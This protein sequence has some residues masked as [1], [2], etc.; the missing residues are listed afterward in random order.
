MTVSN[1]LLYLISHVLANTVT[2]SRLDICPEGWDGKRG[3]TEKGNSF[4]SVSSSCTLGKWRKKDSQL[5]VWVENAWKYPFPMIFI[6]LPLLRHKKNT[7]LSCKGKSQCVFPC[8][9][10]KLFLRATCRAKP[11]HSSHLGITE[12]RLC[13]GFI[14]FSVCSNQLNESLLSP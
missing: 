12:R 1:L 11:P 2:H 14:Y 10:L 5:R 13:I 3:N 4:L 9:R 8:S 7:V 6:S